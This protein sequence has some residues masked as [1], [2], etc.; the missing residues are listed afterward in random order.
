MLERVSLKKPVVWGWKIVFNSNFS[1]Q[2]APVYGESITTVNYLVRRRPDA[3]ICSVAMGCSRNSTCALIYKHGSSTINLWK[4]GKSVTCRNSRWSQPNSTYPGT[5]V[6]DVPGT[7]CV[8]SLV[9]L[10][11]R[12]KRW[13]CSQ[14]IHD[15]FKNNLV[16]PANKWERTE[17]SF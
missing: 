6:H 11:Q 2:F 14:A 1:K 9:S 5:Y 3:R 7:L 8:R 16:D 17:A 10:V 4:P 13:F 15:V 12:R